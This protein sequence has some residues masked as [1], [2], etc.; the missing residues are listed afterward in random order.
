MEV[1]GIFASD[2]VGDGAAA[3]FARCWLLSFCVLRHCG[4]LLR[5]SKRKLTRCHRSD[6][7]SSSSIVLNVPLA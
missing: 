2:D 3:G 4:F 6:R 5:R 1:Y 7:V